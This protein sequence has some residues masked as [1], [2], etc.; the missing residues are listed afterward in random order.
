MTLDNLG[1][2]KSVTFTA[3]DMS[4]TVT[5]R[6]DTFFV[7]HSTGHVHTYGS[8]VAMVLKE[9]VPDDDV[10]RRLQLLRVHSMAPLTFSQ[11]L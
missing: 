7:T 10:L 3:N 2:F 9:C 8:L 5:F 4:R 11:E 6:Q 1:E